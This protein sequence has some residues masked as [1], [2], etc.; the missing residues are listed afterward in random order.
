MDGGGL[1]I[2]Q[3]QPITAW[4]RDGEIFL[5]EPGKPESRIG[6]GKDV[7]IAA[8]NKG[9]YVAW[10]NGAAIEILAPG[11]TQPTQLSTGGAF[12]NLIALPDGSALAA[13][14]SNGTIQIDRF[15]R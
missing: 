13:W 1:A 3:G 14:E 2:H 7:A 10:S 15:E 12:V 5:A 11:T 6:K 9:A 4:R 8:G